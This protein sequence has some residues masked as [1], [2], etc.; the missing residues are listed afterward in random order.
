V[1]IQHAA[2]NDHQQHAWKRFSSCFR[3]S[4]ALQWQASLVAVS[5]R[6]ISN[7][8][9]PRLSLNHAETAKICQHDSSRVC[10]VVS[11]VL[12]AHIHAC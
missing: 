8:L 11:C 4:C 6:R 12:Q 7:C 10:T 1:A 9:A 2:N 5:S 3:A